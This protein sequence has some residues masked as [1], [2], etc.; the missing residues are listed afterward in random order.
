MASQ[1]R[2][3]VID[4]RERTVRTI[5]RVL[6]KEGYEVVTA[7]DGQTGLQEAQ[8]GNPDLIILDIMMPGMNGYEVCR[9]LRADPNTARIAVLFLTGRGKLDNTRDESVFIDRV[10][11]R[12]A[13]F[14]AGAVEFLSKPVRR[15]D[16]LDRVSGLLWASGFHD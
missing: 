11:E 9:R 1:A 16:L 7:L 8:K 4:D 12:L 14:D 6:E 10:R 5:A 3:L 2:I 15:Q 13:G